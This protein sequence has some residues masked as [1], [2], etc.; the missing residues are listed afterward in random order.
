[1]PVGRQNFSVWIKLYPASAG[2]GV[3]E[4]SSHNTHVAS[5]SA[6]TKRGFALQTVTEAAGWAIEYSHSF[7]KR[8]LS[9]FD[10][11]RLDAFMNK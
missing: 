4:F 7:K 3:G 6:T 11:K 10:Q 8:I 5:T 9:N 1:M 2:I